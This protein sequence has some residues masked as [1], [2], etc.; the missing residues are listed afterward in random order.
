MGQAIAVRTD[1][2]ADEVRRFATSQTLPYADRN[3]YE[4]SRELAARWRPSSI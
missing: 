3:A 1:F 2:S 4:Q